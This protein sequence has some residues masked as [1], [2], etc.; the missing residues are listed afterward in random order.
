M[1]ARCLVTGVTTVTKERYCFVVIENCRFDLCVE[2][3]DPAGFPEHSEHF[4]YAGRPDRSETCLDR[5]GS[6][7]CKFYHDQFPFGKTFV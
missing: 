4:G 7:H 1:F 3:F 2:I 5:S 6:S